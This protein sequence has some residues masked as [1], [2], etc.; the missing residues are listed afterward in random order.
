MIREIKGKPVIQPGDT[1]YSVY[2]EEPDP[3]SAS[4]IEVMEHESCFA[5]DKE[6]FDSDTN[7][8]FLTKKSAEAAKAKIVK[9]LRLTED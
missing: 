5:M 4:D 2:F 9:I 7:N 8:W 1:F 6:I 3:N